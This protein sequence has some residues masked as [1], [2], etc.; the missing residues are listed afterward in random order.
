MV[1]TDLKVQYID[2]KNLKQTE[3]NPR[4]WNDKAKADLKDSISRFGLVDPLLVNSSAKRHNIVIGGH[5]R[6]KVA[7]E[8][9]INKVPVIYID[10]SD[11]EREKELVIRLN[12]NQGE[13]DWDLLKEFDENLLANIGFTSE[14][15][16]D[17]FDISELVP[18]QFDLKK[19]LEKLDI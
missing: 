8:L 10:I 11:L 9:G 7:Q 6:L 5:F 1:K 17:L 3:Y 16:D 18:E 4:L 2:V 12:K 15:L 19:E 14:E 13:W